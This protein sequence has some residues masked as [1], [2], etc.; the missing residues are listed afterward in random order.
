MTIRAYRI[1]PFS[2]AGSLAALCLC[3]VALTGCRFETIR[4]EDVDVSIEAM[5]RSIADSWNA[6]DLDG[7]MAFYADGSGTALVTPEGPVYGRE[8]IRAVYAPW[9]DGG[10]R[11]ERIRF[12]DVGVRSLPPL[13]G[14]VTGRRVPQ[15]GSRDPS[16]GWFT[17]VVRRVGDGWRIV[18]DHPEFVYTP[19]STPAEARPAADDAETTAQ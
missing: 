17:L 14:I 5:L 7:V 6:G 16:A 1:R 3:G 13:V 10:V 12:E 15:A 9:F 2:L 11:R 19:I 18:H 8:A 4:E